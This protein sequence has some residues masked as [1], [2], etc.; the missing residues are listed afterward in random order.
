MA[1]SID[2]GWLPERSKWGLLLAASEAFG[3]DAP[4]CRG[5][6]GVVVLT[7]YG[8]DLASI[9]M[10]LV[11]ARYERRGLGRALM[12]HAVRAAGDDATVTLFATSMGR[13]LYEKLGFALVRDS[14]SFIGE[15]RPDPR[16]ADSGKPG[17]PAGTLPGGAG[18]VIREGTLD[19]LA[20]IFAADLAAFGA[21]RA[22]ILRPVAELADRISVLDAGGAVT[23]Y[24]IGW[25]NDVA[26][27]VIGPLLAPDDAAA[28]RLVADVAAHAKTPVR[29]DLDPACP[30]LPAWAEARGLAL[31]GRTVVMAHGALPG[32][33]T[34][35]QLYT[36]VSVALA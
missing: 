11:A 28:R 36:P 6:A 2:R 25:R 13:P 3:I 17:A 21:D 4:D 15:F 14:V 7:R 22:H 5:L 18:G 35:A 8:P 29:L 34:P 33:G 9:G 26:S 30:G 1:L 20:A 19:D 12:E 24:A 27:T 23:G 31:G 10:M 16:S 32:R